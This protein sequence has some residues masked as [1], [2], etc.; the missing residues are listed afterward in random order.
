MI[1]M[2]ATD[3]GKMIAPME[4]VDSAKSVDRYDTSS[5]RYGMRTDGESGFV[6]VNHHQRH[7]KLADIEDVVIDTGE[8]RFP[9]I[10]VKGEICFFMPFNM[11]LDDETL[12]YAT[13]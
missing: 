5:L 6:F 8:V 12:I 11:K 4:A 1:H 3:F 13:G 10:S 9:P 2:F 7:K